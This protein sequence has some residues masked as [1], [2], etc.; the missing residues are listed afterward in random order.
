LVS[1]GIFKAWK[2]INFYSFQYD[3][4]QPRLIDMTK[5]LNSIVIP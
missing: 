2:G 3:R 5:W 4:V 1:A